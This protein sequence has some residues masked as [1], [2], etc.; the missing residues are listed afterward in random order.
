ML[1]DELVGRAAVA[2]AMAG[3]VLAPVH[4]LSRFATQEGA[5]DLDSGVVR[6]WAEPAADLLA[7]LLDWGSA[8]TVYTTYGKLYTPL[9]LAA[10]LCA[11]AVRRR[12]TPTGAEKWGW[13]ILLPGLLAALLGVTGSYWTPWLDE[14]FLL[15][16][17]AVLVSLIG[18]TVL[19]IALLRRGFRPRATSLLLATWFPL[20]FVLSAVIAMGA[21][22]LPLL[23]AFGAAGW[24]LTAASAPAAERIAT[25]A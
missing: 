11:F 24:A 15:T 12:R 14:F 25:R 7:P 20:F 8:D 5:E 23:W 18:S 1:D 21:A 22:L 10:L 13:R 6:A 9:L 16:L 3:T 19:G 4:A 17:P 2:A